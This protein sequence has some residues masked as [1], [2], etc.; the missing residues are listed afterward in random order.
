MRRFK[1]SPAMVVA[2]LALVFAM[3][4]TGI[5]AETYVVSSS[6]QIK[7]G[8]ISNKDLSKAVRAQLAKAGVP[9]APG[10]TGPQ[11]R[12][13]APNPNAAN[14]DKLGG[15][16]ASAYQSRVR[17]ALVSANGSIITQS[18]GITGQRTSAGVYVL[19]FG[20]ALAGKALITT[21]NYALNTSGRIDV[22]AAPCG[23]NLTAGEYDCQQSPGL[24]DGQHAVV[25]T[26]NSYAS[27]WEP[28]TRATTS[29]SSND[30]V[31]GGRLR[32]LPPPS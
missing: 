29:H 19:G 22:S 31:G 24:N 20:E 28:R 16:S 1:P 25:Y 6:K 30:E 4:G 26:A 11:G 12:D 18:G 14:A 8:S 2:L 5:A 13:G 17:W 7:D 21:P 32:R 23:A 3:A 9:G 15:L 27:E 10:L